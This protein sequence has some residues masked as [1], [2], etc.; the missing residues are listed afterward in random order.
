MKM[1][2]KSR[3]TRTL[4]ILTSVGAVLYL[5]FIAM[6]ILFD[7]YPVFKAFDLKEALLLVFIAGFA[8]SWKNKKMAAGIL[9]MIWNA[10]VWIDD[11]YLNRP[12]M[13]YSMGSAIASLFLLIGAF[14][15]FEWYKNSK[16]T[17]PSL[18]QQWRFILRVLLFNYAVLYFIVV[19]SELSVGEPVNYFSFPFIIY[20]L[21]LLIFCVGFLLSWKW[22]FVAGYIFLFWF[23]ILI[24]AN[25]AYS[26]ILTLGGWAAFG[27]PILLQGIFYIKNH[28]KFR[29]G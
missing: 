22:E 18:Q 13:D 2:T 29:P 20:P 12:E 6:T 24:V 5:L 10:G 28:N 17:V 19:F 15:L 11:L 9:F 21:L 8:L 4:Q 14:F 27:I 1:K 3:S 23:A 25:V 26:E 16:T 7:S